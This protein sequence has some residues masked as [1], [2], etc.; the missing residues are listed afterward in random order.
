[1]SKTKVIEKRSADI[2]I[3]IIDNGFILN[4]SGRDED[5][6]W[7]SKKLYCHSEETL[8]QGISDFVSIPEHD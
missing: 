6:N 2:Q 4:V 7:I 8:F 1:M 3:E 5:D